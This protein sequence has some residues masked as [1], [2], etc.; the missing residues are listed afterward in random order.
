MATKTLH[1]IINGENDVAAVLS[2]SS[3]CRLMSIGSNWQRIRVAL[4]LRVTDSGANVQASP[5]FVVGVCAGTS[6]PFNNGAASTQHFFGCYENGTTWTRTAESGG[7]PAH[8]ATTTNGGVSIRRIGTTTGWA[9]GPLHY[10]QRFTTQTR[11]LYFVDIL[12]AAGNWS[13]LQHGKG[14][15]VD[16]YDC[17]YEDFIDKAVLDTFSFQGHSQY[18]WRSANFSPNEADNG[19][20]DAVNVSWDRSSPK[21]E[22]SDLAIVRFA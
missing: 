4:R 2:N 9:G 17:T 15:P 13:M 20:F 21:I 6:H 18:G 3:L 7:V 11:C 19:Y 16:A 1:R 10:T 12:K 22:I 8:Y 5:V 14:H